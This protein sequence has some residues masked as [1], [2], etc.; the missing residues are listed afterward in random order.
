MYF[1]NLSAK[2]MYNVLYSILQ[3]NCKPDRMAWD[4]ESSTG[5]PYRDTLFY[6]EAVNPTAGHILQEAP[7]GIVN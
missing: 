1:F 5:M 6:C 7:M 2:M 3:R 4:T